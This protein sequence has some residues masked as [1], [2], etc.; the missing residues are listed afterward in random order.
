MLF[1]NLSLVSAKVSTYR[2]MVGETSSNQSGK[3]FLVN[4]F[5]IYR[6]QIVIFKQ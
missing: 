1:S 6:F 5:V 3:I 4:Y 2:I